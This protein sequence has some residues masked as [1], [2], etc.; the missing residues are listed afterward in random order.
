MAYLYTK[1]A[2]TTFHGKNPYPTRLLFV[3]EVTYQ[4]KFLEAHCAACFYTNRLQEAREGYKE[5]VQLTKTHPHYF[6]PEDIQKIQMNGQFF[7]R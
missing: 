7:N 1:F 2:K 5:I 3:D 4:W 6:T